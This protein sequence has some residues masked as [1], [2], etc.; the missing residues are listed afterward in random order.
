M[1]QYKCKHGKSTRAIIK[2]CG[3]TEV[4]CKHGKVSQ[5]CDKDA[6]P[7]ESEA[8]TGNICRRV[9]QNSHLAVRC[10]NPGIK[11]WLLGC[12]R[13]ALLTEMCCFCIV[14]YQSPWFT[15]LLLKETLGQSPNLSQFKR[16]LSVSLEQWLAPADVDST[17]KVAYIQGTKTWGSHLKFKFLC[18]QRCAISFPAALEIWRN[19]D[20]RQKTSKWCCIW[21]CH[22]HPV[23][24]TPPHW[25]HGLVENH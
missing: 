13:G 20:V 25:F 23:W 8:M 5:V 24:P 11:R 6:Q 3:E 1:L 15:Q 14:Y 10:M 9:R 2:F 21:F 4:Q 12:Y 19:L 18:R 16:T 7:F 17:H 22:H